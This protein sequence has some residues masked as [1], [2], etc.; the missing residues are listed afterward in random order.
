VSLIHRRTL[1][2]W[3]QTRR[4]ARLKTAG[5][6]AVKTDWPGKVAGDDCEHLNLAIPEN[7]WQNSRLRAVTFLSGQTKKW[8][9]ESEV[10]G[11]A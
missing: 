5:E 10:L 8:I 4:A 6:F 3:R 2:K 11:R 1:R 9:V 7:V